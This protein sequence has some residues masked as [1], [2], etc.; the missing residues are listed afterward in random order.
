MIGT[1]EMAAY[2]VEEVAE[3]LGLSRGNAYR[4]VRAGEIPAKRVGRRWLVPRKVFHAWLD[5]CD[6]PEAV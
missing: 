5:N 4:A 2:S 3:L 6:L 1:R